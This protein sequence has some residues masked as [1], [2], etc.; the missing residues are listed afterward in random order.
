MYLSTKKLLVILLLSFINLKTAHAQK[1]DV[2]L[3]TLNVSTIDTKG[4]TVYTF[5]AVYG[6]AYD[7]SRQEALGKIMVEKMNGTGAY[8]EIDRNCNEVITAYKKSNS[9]KQ[10]KNII[11][12]CGDNITTTGELFN[13]KDGI[14]RNRAI[15][16]YVLY[17]GSKVNNQTD[18]ALLYEVLGESIK[19]E[20]VLAAKLAKNYSGEFV[21]YEF[22]RNQSCYSAMEYAKKKMKVSYI[23]CSS[24]N[25]DR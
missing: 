5:Y 11:W 9:S 13:P 22:L 1:G 14:L 24:V 23:Q 17:F 7:N 2:F 8:F 12:K 20:S 3:G 15:G 6:P 10:N 21:G 25:A 4:K 19:N 16:T 18:K